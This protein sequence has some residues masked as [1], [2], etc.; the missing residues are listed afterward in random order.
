MLIIFF[1]HWT[2]TG[3]RKVTLFEVEVQICPTRCHTKHNISA[4]AT[5]KSVRVHDD[6]PL[7]GSFF[8]DQCFLQSVCISRHCCTWIK[9]LSKCSPSGS[10]KAIRGNYTR[11][12]EWLL[13]HSLKTLTLIC[14][15]L[16]CQSNHSH[17][18]VISVWKANTYIPIHKQQALRQ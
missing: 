2:L 5:I 14:L 6:V 18:T 16:C 7:S 13:L 3:E 10:R 12:N 15:T 11:L 8:R 17:L 4:N 1:H 9:W